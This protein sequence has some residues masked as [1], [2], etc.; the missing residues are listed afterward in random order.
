MKA[1][2]KAISW[3]ISLFFLAMILWPIFKVNNFFKQKEDIAQK[4]NT[5]AKENEKIKDQKQSESKQEMSKEIYDMKSANSISIPEAIVFDKLK[6]GTSD[7]KTQ[8]KEEKKEIFSKNISSTENSERTDNMIVHNPVKAMGVQSDTAENNESHDPAKVSST[9][10]NQ[11]IPLGITKKEARVADSSSEKTEGT[12]N[13][14]AKPSEKFD[15]EN[16]SRN[17]IAIA[18]LKNGERIPILTLDGNYYEEG[19]KFYGFVCVARP[20][21]LPAEPFFF[22]VNASSISLVKQKCPFIGSYYPATSQKNIQFQ[23][24]LSRS[25]YSEI[26]KDVEFQLIYAPTDVNKELLVKSKVKSILDRYQVHLSDVLKIQGK[27]E[28]VGDGYILVIKSFLKANGEVVNV[29]DPD[30]DRV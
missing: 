14:M 2:K 4:D 19:L 30:D 15:F 27:F 7:K 25:S 13:A 24:L 6:E 10:L 18:G 20:V 11:Q 21:I 9:V 28:K 22:I 8:Q 23:Y 5:A 16:Y 29:K 26:A 3:L 1:N 12:K 17:L